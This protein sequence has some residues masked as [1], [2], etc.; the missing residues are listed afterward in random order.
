MP[1]SR[2]GLGLLTHLLCCSLP[3]GTGRLR[4]GD[5]GLG[6]QPG[7]L[8][9]GPEPPSPPCIRAVAAGAA[10]HAR[11]FPDPLAPGGPGAAEPGARRPPPACTLAASLAP[12]C[13]LPAPH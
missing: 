1:A 8:P 11:G 5:V 6:G 7:A 2:W 10:A 9:L 4:F 13:G 12:S 3:V